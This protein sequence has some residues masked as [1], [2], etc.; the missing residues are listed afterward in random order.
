MNTTETSVTT[1]LNKES[2]KITTAL[3]INWEGITDEEVREIAQQ[4][5]IVKVQGQWRRD[6]VIPEG[7]HT[8]NAVDHKVGTRK[9][10][11]KQS[12]ESLFA[13]LSPE[14]RAALV[15]KYSA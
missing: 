10:P 1:R 7:E 8:I 3:T 15:E 13:K 5:L 9:A 11:T 6:E 2:D 4:A 14:E 12:A